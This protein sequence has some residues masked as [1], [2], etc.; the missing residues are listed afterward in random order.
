[1]NN[2]R[3]P[4][5]SDDFAHDRWSLRRYRFTLTFIEKHIEKGSTILD[6]GS[7]NGLG[8]F[9]ESNG[10]C[11][12][13][14]DGSDFDY[15][16]GRAQLWRYSPDCVTALEILEHLLNPFDVLRSMPGK[17]L[18][19]SVPLRL[20]F[21]KAFWNEK[22]PCGKHYH[23]FEIRQFDFLIEKAGW[24]IIDRESHTAPTFKLGLRMLLRWIT[25]RYY[26]IY[27]ERK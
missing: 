18:I 10:Y 21:A 12:I 17:K 19:A 25:K 27:A 7:I 23:E 4:V 24:S 14:T 5:H 20:W 13:N 6:L 3:F 16:Q 22:N 8:Q 9:I 15:P 2:T 11:V 26:L 1:M